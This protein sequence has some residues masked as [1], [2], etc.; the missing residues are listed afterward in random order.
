MPLLLAETT[1][2]TGFMVVAYLAIAAS[3]IVILV[4]LFDP[5]IRYKIS[6]PSSE[7]NTS[8]AFAAT[9]ELLTDSKLTCSP[10]LVVLTNGPQFYEAELAAIAAAKHSI[11]LVAYIF[12]E[13]QIASR[14]VNALAER[15]RAGV[16]VNV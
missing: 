3:V 6:A 16:H 12:H 9:L 5:G 14:Y 4:A 10:E 15:A 2:S 8:D 13:G 11:C 1:V 7:D